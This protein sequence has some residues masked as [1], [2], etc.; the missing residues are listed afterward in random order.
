MLQ[1]NVF[2][3]ARER[4]IVCFGCLEFDYEIYLAIFVIVIHLVDYILSERSSLC[5]PLGFF[6]IVWGWYKSLDVLGGWRS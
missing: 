4:A 2:A 6:Y 5:W 1:N 3:E